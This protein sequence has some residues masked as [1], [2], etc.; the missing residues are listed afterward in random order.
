M[1]RLD[2]SELQTLESMSRLVGSFEP[3]DAGSLVERIRKQPFSVVLLDEF[4]K[5]HPDVHNILLQILDDGRL[6]DGKGRTV[7]FRNAVI[8]MT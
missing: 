3:A 1:I 5:A 6:T 4:E 7:N 8:V 2:M